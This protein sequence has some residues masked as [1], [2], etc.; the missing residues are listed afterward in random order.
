MK[1]RTLLVNLLFVNIGNAVAC[2]MEIMEYLIFSYVKITPLCGF[3][4]SKQFDHAHMKW[5]LS[6][7]RSGNMLRILSGFKN[8]YMLFWMVGGKNKN[9]SITRVL[10]KQPLLSLN[11]I[12]LQCNVHSDLTAGNHSFLRP[13]VHLCW[14]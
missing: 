10:Y 7:L 9:T 1:I 8:V 12:R 14:F 2:F 3:D 13:E 4:N 11:Q 6:I 5:F